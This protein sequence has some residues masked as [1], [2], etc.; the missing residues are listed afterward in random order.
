MPDP[1]RGPLMCSTKL[2]RTNAARCLW[3]RDFNNGGVRKLRFGR[4]GRGRRGDLRVIYYFRDNIGRIY[5]LTLYRKN[6]QDNLTK[7]QRNEMK[8]LTARLD[9]EC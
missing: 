8:A 4:E 1:V 9:G 6:V 2:G 3:R 5:M 7:E